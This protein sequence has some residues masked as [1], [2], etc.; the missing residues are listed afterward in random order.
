MLAAQNLSFVSCRVK[1]ARH[2]DECC[3]LSLHRG[4]PLQICSRE[5]GKQVDCSADARWILTVDVGRLRHHLHVLK[6]PQV[7]IV[8]TMMIVI[9]R[10]R[11]MVMSG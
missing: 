5:G 2:C 1:R 3:S 10:M 4:V 9:L 7:V 8:L 6:L 11:M